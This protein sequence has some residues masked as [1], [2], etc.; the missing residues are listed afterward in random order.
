MSEL[1]IHHWILGTTDDGPS[2]ASCYCGISHGIVST[3]QWDGHPAEERCRQPHDFGHRWRLQFNH[4][5]G[6]PVGV[7]CA[8]CGLERPVDGAEP[9]LHFDEDDG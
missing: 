8:R 9:H 1:H 4:N 6:S 5:D 7:E 2:S 3:N